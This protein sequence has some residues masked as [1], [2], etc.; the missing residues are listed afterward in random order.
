MGRGMQ[1]CINAPIINWQR[2][3]NSLIIG[4]LV[5]WCI[6]A[7]MTVVCIADV[8]AWDAK[9]ADLEE[10]FLLWATPKTEY[11][12]AAKEEAYAVLTADTAAAARV[13]PKFMGTPS[14]SLRDKILTFCENAEPSAVGPAFRPHAA[15]DSP[16]LGL[17]MFCLSRS[18]DTE[19]LPILL[20]HLK[21]RRHSLRSTAALSL[22][23]LGHPGAVEDL[24]RAMETETHSMT[25]KSAAF[26]LGQCGDTS[27]ITARL[28]D[29]LINGLDD[30]FFAVRLN[31]ALALARLGEPAVGRLLE[32]YETLSDTAHYGALQALGRSTSAAGRPMLER[33]SADSSAASPLRGV[34]LKSLLDRAWAP[35]DTDLADLRAMPVGRGLWGLSK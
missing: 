23:Y 21:H 19:S 7:L 3:R 28:L 17:A 16:N 13:L 4:A 30:N 12:G 26:A 10:A 6:G 31:S 33:I 27:T 2:M 8:S 5:H 9:P 25:R 35:A 22:G 18:H 15:A 14:G 11:S 20:E 24:I 34:A 32:R 29:A 1:Q